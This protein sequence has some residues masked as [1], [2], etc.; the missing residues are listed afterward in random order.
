MDY[1]CEM[2]LNEDGSAKEYYMIFF[3]VEKDTDEIVVWTD[4]A[5]K[6]TDSSEAFYQDALRLGLI[7]DPKS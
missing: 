6:W 3:L 1:G 7:K 2:S 4:L 5:V